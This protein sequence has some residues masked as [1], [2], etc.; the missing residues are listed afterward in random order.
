MSAA[1]AGQELVLKFIAHDH[2]VYQDHAAFK[3]YMD[4]LLTTT[5]LEQEQVLGKREEWTRWINL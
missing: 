2:Q 3:A 1:L 4:L 5:H